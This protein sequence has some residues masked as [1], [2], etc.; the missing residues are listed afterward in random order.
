MTTTT[1]LD[2]FVGHPGTE[3]PFSVSDI[4]RAATQR[5]GDDW[6][7]ESWPWGVGAYVEHLKAGS[8]CVG[9]D[10]EGDLGVRLDESKVKPEFYSGSSADG[11]D[12]CAEWLVDAIRRLIAAAVTS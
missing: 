1:A 4:A 7:C 2:P 12:A 10:D 3:Y 8:F 11:L 9:V 6:A 5:L